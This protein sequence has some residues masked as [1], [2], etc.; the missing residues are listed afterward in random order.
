MRIGTKAWYLLCWLALGAPALHAGMALEVGKAG[1]G[2]AFPL[3]NARQIARS[4]SGIWFLAYDG[5]VDG[6]PAIFLAAS[7]GAAPEV[8]G[9]FESAIVLVGKSPRALI[10]SDGEPHLASIAVGADNVLHVVWQGVGPD[11]VHY[12]RASVAA[13][14]KRLGEAAS[15]TRADGRTR[16]SERLD[17]GPRSAELGDVVVDRAGRLWVIY[18]QLVSIAPTA[19]YRFL[20]GREEYNYKLGGSDGYEIWAATPAGGAWKRSRLTA[21]GPYRF[22]VL[23]LDATGTLHLLFGQKTWFL[24]YLQLPD[25]AARFD[26]GSG[27]DAVPPQLAWYGTLYPGY[28]VAGLG[29]Q[30]IVAFE[31]VEGQII[32]AHFDGKNWTRQPLHPS[33][34]VFHHPLLARDEHGVAWLLWHNATRS[35]TFYSRWMGSAFGTAYECRSMLGPMTAR[36]IGD[37]LRGGLSADNLPPIT[38]HTVQKEMA[39]GSGALGVAVQKG[40]GSGAVYFDRLVVPELRAEPGSKVLFVDMLQVGETDGLVETFHPMK[41]HPANP[42]LRPGPKGAFDDLRAHAYGEVVHENGLFRMWYSGWPAGAARDPQN[43]KHYVGYAESRDG[44]SWVKRPLGQVEYGGTREN[45]IVDL[46]D[47]G[48]DTYMPMVVQDP[49]DKDPAHRYK[50][51]VEQ[52]RGNTLHYSADALRWT[53]EGPVNPR[54]RPGETQRNPAYWGDRRNVFYDTLEKDPARRWKVYSHCSGSPDHVRKTCRFWSPDLKTWSPDPANP[55]LHPRAGSEIE[56]HMTSVWNYGGLYIGMFDVWD[57]LQRMPQQM[58]ASRDG[59]NFVHVFDGRGVIEL[60]KPGEWDAG[61]TSP[62]NVPIEVG[63]EIWY[64]Y[65]G[66]AAPIGFLTDFVY[67][68]MSTGLATIRRDGFVSL[69]IAQGRPAGTV[70]SIPFR[71]ADRPIALE[72]NAEGLAG[73]KGRIAVDLLDGSSVVATSNWLS[74]DGVHVPVVWPEQGGVLRLAAGKPYRVRVRLEGSARLYSFSFR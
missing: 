41:K 4:T 57:S 68:P 67:T 64:Y 65:S 42:V 28:T 44:V 23:D 17:A 31:K 14:T 37:P 47:R 72:I 18:S 58:I 29:R 7:R 48:E 51:I 15:W 22:P 49:E 62:V 33:R 71:A 11:A 35:H 55:I 5:Q 8:T 43:Y 59:R 26:S 69:D 27:L 16:G 56:Q 52:G 53:H 38:I 40:D 19:S 9:D 36:E 39:A 1:S 61:W 74:A 54:R 24:F 45:N 3:G 63:D 21:P 70:T 32:T 30:A 60:G 13:G 2:P 10:K 50:M 6:S 34:E 73:G 12:S 66:N 46:D 20:D 25:F